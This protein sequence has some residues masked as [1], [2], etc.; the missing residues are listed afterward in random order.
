MSCIPSLIKSRS[1]E[2]GGESVLKAVVLYLFSSQSLTSVFL[3]LWCASPFVSQKSNGSLFNWHPT[4]LGAPS[5]LLAPFIAFA[6]RTSSRSRCSLMCFTYFYSFHS[7][8]SVNDKITMSKCR[9]DFARFF[10]GET[11]NRF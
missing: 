9:L 10:R 6:A 5:V 11:L 8:D 1:V 7:F 3:S 4:M 2:E